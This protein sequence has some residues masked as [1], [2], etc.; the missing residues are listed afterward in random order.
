MLKSVCLDVDSMH[1][2]FY[3]AQ[4]AQNYSQSTINFEFIHEILI[5]KK[6]SGEC[7]IKSDFTTFM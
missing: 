2:F 5:R 1:L 7:I 4:M 3:G 6:Y